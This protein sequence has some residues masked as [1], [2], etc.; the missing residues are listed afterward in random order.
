V[1][2]IHITT[3][4]T[5]TQRYSYQPPS[6]TSTVPAAAAAAAAAAAENERM[7]NSSTPSQQL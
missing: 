6:Q 2:T 4:D 3:S 5:H 1:N 7:I